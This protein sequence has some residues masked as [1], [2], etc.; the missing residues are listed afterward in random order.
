MQILV[1]RLS[2]SDPLVPSP[3][4]EEEPGVKT[5][6]PPENPEVTSPN[7]HLEPRAEGM[8]EERSR[9][10]GD[11][12]LAE[13]SSLDDQVDQYIMVASE[14]NVDSGNKYGPALPLPKNATPA[15]NIHAPN[16]TISLE[17]LEQLERDNPFDDFDLL[18][19]SDTFLSKSIG[20]SSYTSIGGLSQT[21]KESL[22]S[23]FRSKVLDIDLF[24]AIEQDDN[25]ISE[26]MDLFL[27]LN[28]SSF[29]SKFQEF[30]QVLDPLME[31]IKRSLH[32]KKVDKSKLEERNLGYDRLMAEVTAF[33]TKLAAFREEILDAQQKVEEID[34]TI[35]EYKEKIHNLELQKASIQE[36]ESFMKKEAS[37][38]IRKVKE[39]K[40]FQQE[41]KTLVE[42]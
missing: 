24:Q 16:V 28:Q 8:E 18:V 19:Q 25:I 33:H 32:Q 20:K 4:L 27:K 21:S 40:I 42:H 3:I 2:F 10:G 30:W 6:P 37:L 29:G 26:V 14:N 9:E 13:D 22:L 35:S 38:A 39:S 36:R 34:S 17:E 1:S 15:A 23:E 12:N 11:R 41:I 31:N 5:S 7:Q